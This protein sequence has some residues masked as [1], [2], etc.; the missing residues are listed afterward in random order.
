MN[1]I[2]EIIN[3][4]F[5]VNLPYL[6]SVNSKTAIFDRLYPNYRVQYRLISIN[7]KHHFNNSISCRFASVT[8]FLIYT[9]WNAQCIV[10]SMVALFQFTQPPIL[11]LQSPI[12]ILF[13]QLQIVRRKQ[14][15]NAF[16]AA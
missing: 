12:R 16:I 2:D 15:A 3:L 1:S 10:L 6:F 7:I 5:I 14:N 9:E 4:M 13:D 11:N 8:F